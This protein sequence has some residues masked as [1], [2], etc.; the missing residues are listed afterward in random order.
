MSTINGFRLVFFLSFSVLL[1]CKLATNTYKITWVLELEK[2]MKLEHGSA[3]VAKLT[4]K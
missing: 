4:A 2:R 3:V 1:A